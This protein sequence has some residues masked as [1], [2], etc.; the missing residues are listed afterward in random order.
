MKFIVLT[1]KFLNFTNKHKKSKY[2][3]K[4]QNFEEFFIEKY[5]DFFI[6]TKVFINEKKNMLK[7]Q[8]NSI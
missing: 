4:T 5:L 8:K 1:K 3:I 2:F 7:F 6:K